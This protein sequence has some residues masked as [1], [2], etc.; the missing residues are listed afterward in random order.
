MLLKQCL[1]RGLKHSCLLRFASSSSSSSREFPAFPIA[2]VAITVIFRP[3]GS[4]PAQY[5][6]VK[7]G[8]EPGKGLWSLPGGG[9]D[10]GETT[11]AAAARE[12]AEETSLTEKHVKFYP[13]P[14]TSTDAIYPAVDGSGTR[15]HYVISQVL[16][17]ASPSALSK[18]AASDDAEALGWFSMQEMALT[19]PPV[20][21]SMLHVVNLAERYAQ[22]VAIAEADAT[23]V[24]RGV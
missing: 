20:V 10:T 21:P 14:F 8:K 18:A 3:S 6:L 17:F 12:L 13:H 4:E 9:I 11:L 22:T 23:S 1:I 2:A 16:A 24:P 15:F 7:R 5:L 19:D